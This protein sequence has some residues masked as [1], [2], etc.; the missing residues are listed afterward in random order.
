MTVL[1]TRRGNRRRSRRSRRRQPYLSRKREGGGGERRKPC[2]LPRKQGGGRGAKKRNAGRHE[3]QKRKSCKVVDASNMCVCV[4][5]LPAAR[6]H[7]HFRTETITAK[8]RPT[9][10]TSTTACQNLLTKAV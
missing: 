2:N 10:A 3:R 4:S 6:Q 7:E 8:L 1:M 9:Q 5:V